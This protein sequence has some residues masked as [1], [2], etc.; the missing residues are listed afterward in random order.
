MADTAYVTAAMP[1]GI[2]TFWLNHTLSASNATLGVSVFGKVLNIK[3]FLI[4]L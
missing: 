3:C 4:L 2:A 1:K